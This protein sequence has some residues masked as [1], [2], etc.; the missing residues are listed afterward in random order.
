MSVMER[1]SN[2]TRLAEDADCRCIL[3]STRA[4][5]VG[6]NLTSASRVMVCEPSWNPSVEQQAMDRV[7]RIGQTRDVVATRY[8][9]QGS[10]EET[11]LALQKQ[12]KELATLSLSGNLTSGGNDLAKK[13]LSLKSLLK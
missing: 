10:I 1:E 8:I 11:M 6:L 13:L 9:V 3:V 5:G 7:H 2:L 12:K 4:G